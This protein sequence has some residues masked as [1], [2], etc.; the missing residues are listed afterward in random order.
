MLLLVIADMQMQVYGG[1]DAQEISVSFSERNA[2]GYEGSAM[3]LSDVYSVHSPL[4]RFP[5]G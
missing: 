5:M 4:R 1:E 2:E 3:M